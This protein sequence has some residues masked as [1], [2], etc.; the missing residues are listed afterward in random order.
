MRNAFIS[1]IYEK[2]IVLR[3]INIEEHYLM[4]NPLKE[5]QLDLL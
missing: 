5:V 3:L 4:T 2:T 1:N